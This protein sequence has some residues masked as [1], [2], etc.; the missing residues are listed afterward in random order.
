MFDLRKHASHGTGKP[1]S[2]R[3]AGMQSPLVESYLD[4]QIEITQR[5]ASPISAR[6]AFSVRV[7]GGEPLLQSYI[8]GFL[9]EKSARAAAHAEIEKLEFKY[10][11]NPSPIA[12]ILSSLK[13]Q[14]AAKKL[15]ENHRK[16]A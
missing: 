8:T 1:K 12:G 10:G 7:D 16:S 9:S 3:R 14:R 4:Y 6:I 2:I 15:Q 5:P 11:Q 13:R